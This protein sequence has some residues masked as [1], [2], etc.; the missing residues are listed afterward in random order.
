MGHRL[1]WM[2]FALGLLLATAGNGRVAPAEQAAGI[3]VIC[4]YAGTWNIEIDHFDTANS[5]ASHEKTLL[6]N[7]CWKSGGYFACNQ[8]VNGE[9]KVLI[10]FTYNAKD[11]VYTS[12]QIPPDGSAA[13]SGTLLIDG[14]TWTFPWQSKD[15][16]KTTYFRVVNVFTAPD[17]IE[18]RQEFSTDQAHWTLMAKGLEKKAAGGR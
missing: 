14:N 1:Q 6:R 10:V 4:A 16:D 13:G 9:S 7:D 12:Y 8:Y 3:D 11:N 18:F 5:K 17:R 2:G 15:G